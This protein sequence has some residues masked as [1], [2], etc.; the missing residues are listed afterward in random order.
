PAESLQG[1]L[2]FHRLMVF[3]GIV[4]IAPT[5]GGLPGLRPASAGFCVCHRLYS[6]GPT[7]RPPLFLGGALTPP[8]AAPGPSAPRTRVHAVPPPVPPPRPRSKRVA[9]GQRA[10]AGRKPRTP[11]E[12][13][14]GGSGRFCQRSSSGHYEQA[15]R[16]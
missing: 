7:G 13:H 10:E 16:L 4:R 12:I 2:G 14:P 15:V 1:A 9:D 3:D 5:A 11:A 6:V 8:R